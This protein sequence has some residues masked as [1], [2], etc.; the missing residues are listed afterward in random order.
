M[1]KT[2]L[3]MLLPVLALA[4]LSLFTAVPVSQADVSYDFCWQFSNED[5][6]YYNYDAATGCCK[7][8][9]NHPGPVICP[10]VCF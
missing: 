10:D 7:G 6:V 3:L 9:K 5:C 4:V 1:Q 8:I 2:R